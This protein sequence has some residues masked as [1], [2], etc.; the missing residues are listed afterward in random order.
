MGFK[1]ADNKNASI[2][3]RIFPFNHLLFQNFAKA[4][5]SPFYSEL[6]LTLLKLHKK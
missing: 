5:N 6:L 2:T 4:G 1:Q 3:S